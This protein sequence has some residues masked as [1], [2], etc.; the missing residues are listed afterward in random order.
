[1]YLKNV[2]DIFNSFLTEKNKIRNFF[3]KEFLLL[4]SF[5]LSHELRTQSESKFKCVIKPKFRNAHS[6][7]VHRDLENAE[8]EPLVF[9]RIWSSQENWSF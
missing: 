8:K 6:F 9:R 7:P 4:F 1:M 3:F 5:I 2:I